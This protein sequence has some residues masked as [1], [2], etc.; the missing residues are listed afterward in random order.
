VG[1][2]LELGGRQGL[3]EGEP[4]DWRTLDPLILATSGE[5]EARMALAHRLL[6]DTRDSELAA[7]RAPCPSEDPPSPMAADPLRAWYRQQAH[8]FTVLIPLSRTT[9]LEGVL[10]Q[11]LEWHKPA[12][13]SHQLCWIEAGACLDRGVRV[14]LH[15]LGLSP[16]AAPPVLGQAL[17]GGGTEPLGGAGSS[18]PRGPDLAVMPFLPMRSRQP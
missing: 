15:R 6:L 9:V 13:T 5:D 2:A 18:Q 12:H 1:P 14:G 10:E 8:R 16:R 17:L 11:A 4:D 7:G 3:G